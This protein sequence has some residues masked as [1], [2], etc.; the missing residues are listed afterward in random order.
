[1]EPMEKIGMEVLRTHGFKILSTSLHNAV[2]ADIKGNMVPK[3]IV[4]ELNLI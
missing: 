1:M 3:I 2:Y 4:E